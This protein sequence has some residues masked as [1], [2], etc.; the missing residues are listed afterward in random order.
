ML[1]DLLDASQSEFATIVNQ[2]FVMR[3]EEYIDT[4][5]YAINAL[6]SGTI[7]RRLSDR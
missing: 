7:N 5:S 6:L 2:S 3:D 4:G 1:K